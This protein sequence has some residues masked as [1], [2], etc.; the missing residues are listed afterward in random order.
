MNSKCPECGSSVGPESRF[1]H[2]CG[3]RVFERALAPARFAAPLS[4]TP[5]HL[6][7]RILTTR[8]ALEGE[9][10]RVTVLFCDIANSTALA[11]RLGEERMHELLNRFFEHALEEVH[12]FEG[13][14]NQFLGDGFMA[15]FG[16]P[17]ALEHHEKHA[18]L[19]SLGLRRRLAAHFDD[20]A[21]H[22]QMAIQVRMGLNTGHVVVGK[23]G[24]NLRMDYTANGD[25]T[26][27]AARLQAMA[28]PGEVLIANSTFEAARNMIEALP[29]GQV[30]IRGVSAPLAVHRVT[31]VSAAGS[32]TR[33]SSTRP[34]S[35]FVGRDREITQLLDC[36]EHAES[37]SGQAVGVVSE[38]GMGKTRLLCEFRQRIAERNV[39]FL[40]GQCL[41]YGVSIPY[42]PIFDIVRSTCQIAENDSPDAVREKVRAAVSAG[43][44]DADAATPYLLHVLG[45]QQDMGTLAGLTPEI[46]QTRTFDTLRQLCLR[47]SRRRPLVLVIEDLHWV[48]RSS[49]DFIAA[50]VESLA[51]A[52]ILLIATYRPGYSPA[53]INKSFATQISLRPLSQSGGLSIA[54]GVLRDQGT[55]LALAQEVVTRA[56]GNPLFL[57]ELA[58]A[59]G[60]RSGASGAVPDTLLGVL[61]ARIDRL[62]DDAKRLLQTASVIGREF[63]RPLLGLVWQ[64]DA[65]LEVELARLTRLEFV[66]ERESQGGAA[67]V[68][69]HALTREAAYASLLQG[70][71]RACHGAVG[72]ALEQIHADRLDEAV[73]FLAHQF[74]LSEF[75][76]KAVEYAVR[77]AARA[78][79]RWANTEALAF[80]EAALQ[81]L[82]AMPMSEANRIGRIDIV[83]RQAEVRFALGQHS[84][85][86]AELVNIGMLISPTDDPAHRAAWHYWMGFLNSS[87]GGRTETSIAHCQEASAIAHAAELENLRAAAD[88]C[89]AQVYVLAGELNRAMETGERALEVFERRGD[90]WWACR[91]LSQLIPAANARGEWRRSL[92]YCD[93][94]L[95]HGIAMDDL[96]LKVSAQIRLA[97]TQIQRGDWAAGLAHCEQAQALAPVQFDAAALRA[98]RG[99]GWVKAGR[100]AEGTE[101]LINALAWYTQAHLRYPHTQFSTWLAEGL[102]RA[103][104]FQRAQALLREVLATSEDLGYRYLAG[105]SHRLLAQ[106]LCPTDAVVATVHIRQALAIAESIDAKSELAKAWLLATSFDNGLVEPSRISA[107]REEAF[108]ALRELGATLEVG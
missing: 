54:Q 16:A 74:G 12:H 104:A 82:A 63:S 101:E 84:A 90:R 8:S 15:L 99:F 66:H 45:L 106:S 13:S 21:K 91:T 60:E 39:A 32:G 81:R 4:Y 73:E 31:G 102:L 75:D 34:L 94:A 22:A 30:Q 59:V 77:A 108:D 6:V 17:L 85:Q 58:R 44:A 103:H 23:I 18:I 88:T 65:S 96:R 87:T 62:P 83:I 98:I 56:E 100:V 61:S 97:A 26:H 92:A 107:A 53:W 46:I 55:P 38:P 35:R 37:G 24:D 36:L 28:A 48:D 40:E 68:F 2:A 42:L 71:R 69:K 93:R 50:M 5:P 19:A 49:E 76:D 52:P 33:L 70:R 64:D 3:A 29:L 1:C 10:K 11:E 57:E 67:Y 25:T 89:L 86:L 105:I 7:R 95:V 20:V 14:V 9:R 27:V 72:L 41:S 47:G 51:G 79:V 80:F 78:Q 43:G